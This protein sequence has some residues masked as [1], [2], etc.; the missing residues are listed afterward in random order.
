[1]KPT[2]YLKTIRIKNEDRYKI[3][4]NYGFFRSYLLGKDFSW[5]ELQDFAEYGTRL[6]IDGAQMNEVESA[7][8][9]D[10]LFGIESQLFLAPGFFMTQNLQPI[11][12]SYSPIPEKP[13][14][15]VAR[16]IPCATDC[17]CGPSF[18]EDTYFEPDEA[19]HTPMPTLKQPKGSLWARMFG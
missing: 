10:K 13:A 19:V 1:M 7:L 17:G 15:K 3:V 5:A 14:E 2:Y 12:C 8:S 18:M 16:Q 11:Q 4:A 9:I 6:V